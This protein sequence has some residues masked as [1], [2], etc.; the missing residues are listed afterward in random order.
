[1]GREMVRNLLKAGHAVRAFDLA[2]AA[3]ADVVTE[4]AAGAKSPADAAHGADIVIT[5]LPDTPACRGGDLRRRT[6]S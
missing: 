4:G 6:A 1:M 5:M 3:I 2:E